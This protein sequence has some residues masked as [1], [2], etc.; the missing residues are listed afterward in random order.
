MAHVK[1]MMTSEWCLPWKLTRLNNKC[2]YC[3]T[4]ATELRITV[5]QPG[6]E[7][8]NSTGNLVFNRIFPFWLGH[9]KVRPKIFWSNILKRFLVLAYHSFKLIN[10]TVI[11]IY[12]PNMALPGRASEAVEFCSFTGRGGGPTDNQIHAQIKKKEYQ[13]PQVNRE[14]FCFPFRAV[15]SAI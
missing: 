15:S 4:T 14:L 12:L 1:R 9:T 13:I 2:S 8:L 7:L 11:K 3:S 5:H 6:E 10:Y